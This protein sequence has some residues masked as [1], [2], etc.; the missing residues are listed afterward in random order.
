MTTDSDDKPLDL[1]RRPPSAR[2]RIFSETLR[3]VALDLRDA[4]GP[5]RRASSAAAR[6]VEGRLEHHAVPAGPPNR[7]RQGPE[8][9]PI[10]VNALVGEVL[11]CTLQNLRHEEY[12]GHF[13]RLILATH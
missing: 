13:S 9:D 11:G 1:E 12:V 6:G 7:R 8:V 4:V 10:P 2:A 3:A 5:V